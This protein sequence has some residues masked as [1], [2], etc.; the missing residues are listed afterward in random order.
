MRQCCKS[1]VAVWTGLAIGIAAVLG[2]TATHEPARLSPAEQ[3]AIQTDI[4]AFLEKWVS[5]FE[6]RDQ[7]AVRS[8]LVEDDRFTWYE[9]GTARYQSADA[10]IDGLQRFPPTL[11]FGHEL[12]EV[13][14]IPVTRDIAWTDM[15]TRTE[16]R[17]GGVVVAAFSGAVAMLVERH[18]STWRIVA[19]HSSTERPAQETG[20]PAE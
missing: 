3:L 13:R 20:R 17:Q 7:Q 14:V 2:C 19:A 1:G 9:D 11:T 18:G 8:I 16:I 6:A 5:A 10:V 15:L 12:V 4:K